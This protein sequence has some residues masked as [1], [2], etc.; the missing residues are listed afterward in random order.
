MT[1]AFAIVILLALIPAVAGQAQDSP[2]EAYDPTHPNFVALG[3]GGNA[4]LVGVRY[5]RSLGASPFFAG[6]GMG[7]DGVTPYVEAA[8]AKGV[9]E[10][11][12]TYVSLGL[13]AGWREYANTGSL[14]V[15]FGQRMWFF[16]NWRLFMDY[17]LSFMPPLWGETNL[18]LM[19]FAFPSL[20]VGFTF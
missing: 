14:L 20:Q 9:F 1:R 13:W 19:T 5:A 18:G 4:G 12:Q 17:G 11:S 2:W 3:I 8:R 10:D 7:L 16:G 15:T 6:I